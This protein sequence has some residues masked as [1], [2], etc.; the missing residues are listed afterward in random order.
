MR[1]LRGELLLEAWEQGLAEPEL[2]RALTLLSVSGGGQTREELAAR[3]VADCDAELLR[4]R[5]LTF[6]DALRG[7]LDCKSCATRMEFETSIGSLL[8][9]LE[10]TRAHDEEQWSEGRFTFSMRP[11]TTLDLISIASAPDPRRRLLEL[12]TTVDGTGAES[13]LAPTEN[14]AVERFN[15]L[16]EGAETRFT[17]QCPACRETDY[18]NLDIG[19]FLWAEVRHA[20]LSLL[21]DVHELA[22]AYG[23]SERAILEMPAT[24]RATYL[25]MARA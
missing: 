17:L 23:W 20:A 6:G 18:V 10:A 14:S 24:R 15:R 2:S 1:P 22:S 25:E 7:S 16:N 13:A 11:V 12:C 19:R 3:S 21:R 4:L 8:D 9:R 5:R